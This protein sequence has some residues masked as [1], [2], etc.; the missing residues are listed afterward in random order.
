MEPPCWSATERPPVPIFPYDMKKLPF[1]TFSASAAYSN[2]LKFS[3]NKN[4]IDCHNKIW[5]EE[6]LVHVNY[7]VSKTE[8]II[9]ELSK[10]QVKL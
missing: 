4:I 5:D 10:F 6:H 3:K 7:A 8:K 1:N 2:D 9:D